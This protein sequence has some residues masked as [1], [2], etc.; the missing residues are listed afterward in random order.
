MSSFIA[1]LLFAVYAAAGF[2]NLGTKYLIYDWSET[3]PNFRVS[4]K[5]LTEL[6]IPSVEI[7]NYATAELAIVLS[8]FIYARRL[9]FTSRT[10]RL[11]P[12]VVLVTGVEFAASFFV[13]RLGRFDKWDDAVLTTLE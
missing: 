11:I 12:A 6:P 8:L 1:F 4:K 2:E 10:Q 9:H 3:S 13:A 7:Q 5:L